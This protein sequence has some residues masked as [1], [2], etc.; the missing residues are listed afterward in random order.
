MT[1]RLACKAARNEFIKLPED[2]ARC[3]GYGKRFVETRTLEDER[4]L[5]P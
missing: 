3:A 4:V 1:P 5:G 2:M